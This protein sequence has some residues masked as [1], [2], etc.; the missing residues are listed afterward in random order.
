MVGPF[1]QRLMRWVHEEGFCDEATRD[2]NYVEFFNLMFSGQLDPADHAAGHRRGGRLHGDDAPRRSSMA[3]AVERR[4]LIAPV[5]TTADVVA[6]EQLAARD[7]WD[8][9]DGV[10]C[11]GPFARA[12]AVPLRRLA[13]PPQLGEHQ[14]AAPERPGTDVG[15]ST[16]IATLPEGAARPDSGA[17]RPQGR[18]S[19][20][21][22]R[23]PD[24]DPGAG[25]PRRH[26]RARRIAAP[27]R[28]CSG[29]RALPGGHRRRHRGHRPVALG[30]RR[31]A[32]PAAEPGDAR[33]PGTV[34]RDLVRWG[35]VLVESFSPG[36]MDSL[37]LG[38]RRPAARSTPAW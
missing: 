17:R 25:R 26:R 12:S 19:E 36:T 31:Q 6:S 8:V 37:G 22:R 35:D 13:R 14:V 33:P 11:P 2:L 32:L 21:G 34:V 5:T 9:V 7:M 23:R 28:R 1:T 38:L 30:Q 27:P 16:R 10:R 3:G 24:G 4:L 29:R 18:R 15:G 20:L